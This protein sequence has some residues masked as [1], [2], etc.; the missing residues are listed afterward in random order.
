[1]RYRVYWEDTD[2]GGVVYHARYLHFFE[3]A[4]SDWLRKLGYPQRQL[5]QEAG[6]VFA[7]TRTDTRFLAPAQLEDEL[8]VTVVVETIRAASIVFSQSVFRVS[9]GTLLASADVMVACL[10]ADN[11]KPARP[12]RALVES[13][14]RFKNE[15]D[16]QKPQ[17][18]GQDG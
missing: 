11:F 9:D 6:R 3:R 10:C 1:M 17:T 8:E 2:A 13:I 18:Q 16:Q 12:P 14:Q 7:V 4:R 15:Q 5:K